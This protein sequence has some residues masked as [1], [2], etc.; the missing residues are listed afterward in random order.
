MNRTCLVWTILGSFKRKS[1]LRQV[2]NRRKC[3][4]VRQN[5]PIISRNRL[6]AWWGCKPAHAEIHE[7]TL[8]SSSPRQLQVQNSN[9]T[10]TQRHPTW[11]IDFSNQPPSE[12][13]IA[14]FGK[15]GAPEIGCKTALLWLSEGKWL[16]ARVIRTIRKIS[17]WCFYVAPTEKIKLVHF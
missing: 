11:N 3:W 7:D 15:V 8:N 1:L 10:R 2:K 13:K 14:G 16:L 17:V 9:P 12:T 5:K 4:V 6:K